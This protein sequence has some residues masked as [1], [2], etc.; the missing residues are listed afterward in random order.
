MRASVHRTEVGLLEKGGRI[1]RIDTAIQL[2]GAMAVPVE[3]LLAGI[4]WTAGGPIDGSF[5]IV[6]RGTELLTQRE[7][8][9]Y[10]SERKSNAARGVRPPGRST[11][12]D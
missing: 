8:A 11:Q 3:E 10:R 1:P 9:T 2:A 6:P 5:T 4:R 7:S 12:G